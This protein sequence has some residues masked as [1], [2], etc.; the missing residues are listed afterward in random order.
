LGGDHPSLAGGNSL[1]RVETEHSRIAHGPDMPSLNSSTKAARG[2]FDHN[3]F[4]FVGN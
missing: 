1:T 2:I 3:E 4:V